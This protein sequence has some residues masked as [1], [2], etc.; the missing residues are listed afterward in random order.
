MS[1]FNVMA[2]V[3]WKQNNK[4]LWPYSVKPNIPFASKTGYGCIFMR[5]TMND[6]R[7]SM[8]ASM[9]V[10]LLTKKQNKKTT[11]QSHFHEWNIPA[12]NLYW[13]I[14]VGNKIITRAHCTSI[15]TIGLRISSRDRDVLACE[16]RWDPARISLLPTAKPCWKMLQAA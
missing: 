7:K 15:R 16:G 14:L 2:K 11:P 4:Y 3:L 5:C 8:L 13:F 10:L 6:Q 9:P 12:Q 1:I